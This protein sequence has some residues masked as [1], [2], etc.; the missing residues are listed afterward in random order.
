MKLKILCFFGIHNWEISKWS[1]YKTNHRGK[2]ISL[3]EEGFNRTCKRCHKVQQLQKPDRYDPVAY[4]WK[5]F[6][7]KN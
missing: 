5:D 4:V 1:T 2:I 6:K 3:V 7:N